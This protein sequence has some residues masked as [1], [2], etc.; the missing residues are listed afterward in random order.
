MSS[1]P[2]PFNKELR[3]KEAAE[4]NARWSSLTPS[5]KLASL[6]SRLGTGVGATRQRKL[7]AAEMEIQ[8]G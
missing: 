7:L 6:D 1:R 4:R 3:K 2:W 5:E 8:N